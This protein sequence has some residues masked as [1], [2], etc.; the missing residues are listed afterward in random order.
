M[1]LTEKNGHA[2]IEEIL[3]SVRRIIAEEPGGSAPL[4]DLNAAA[5]HPR[6]DGLLDDPSDFDLPSMFK[7][8]N[9]AAADKP[10]PLF[11]RLSEAI[12]AASNGN[13]HAAEAP[14]SE[15]SL[16][17]LKLHR[18]DAG[19]AG[20]APHFLLSTFHDA[21]TPRADEIAAAVMVDAAPA[22]TPAP[23]NFA[24]GPTMSAPDASHSSSE[25]FPSYDRSETQQAAA[26]T[27]PPQVPRQMAAFKDTRFRSMGCAPVAAQPV[28][29]FVSPFEATAT[30][31][32]VSAAETLAQ[33]PSPTHQSPVPATDAPAPVLAATEDLVAM[34]APASLTAAI[35]A[36]YPS[37]PTEPISAEPSPKVPPPV[38][39]PPA[40]SPAQAQAQ[41][42]APIEDST[43]DL[44]RPM[45]RQWLA[46]N[47][48]RMVEKALHIEVAES[49]KTPKK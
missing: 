17:A 40:P 45:L 6:G 28:Q 10:A 18:V 29:P 8:P 41:P 1:E 27:P 48:P 7:S 3:A 49:V 12:R 22:S 24:P 21:T 36:S 4:I 46:E 34:E 15:Q 35:V 38:P 2:S 43:A 14:R 44:L 11:G 20:A 37:V 31:A 30:A 13:G 5:H 26:P 47:M 33:S 19:E 16:S 25:T 39:A 9:P 32:L 23:S 42:S